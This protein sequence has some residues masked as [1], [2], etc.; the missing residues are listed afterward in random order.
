MKKQGT[1]GMGLSLLML[2]GLA[3]VADAA[4]LA[5][6]VVHSASAEDMAPINSFSYWR[7]NQENGQAGA[8]N[9]TILWANE[10]ISAMHIGFAGTGVGLRVRQ[11]S[12]T[13]EILWRINDGVDGTG[14]IDT[15]YD[16]GDN[17]GYLFYTY[18][19]ASTGTLSAGFHVVSV[20]TNTSLVPDT[21][22]VLDAIEVY[23]PQAAERHEQIYWFFSGGPGTWAADDTGGEANTLA[24]GG[25]ICYTLGEG[26]A[27][28]YRFQGTAAS[29]RVQPRWDWDTVLGWDIDGGFRSGTFDGGDFAD[30]STQLYLDGGSTNFRFSHVL[31]NDLP[32]GAHTLT[33]T[34][35]GGGSNA[36]WSLVLLDALDVID[37]SPSPT[38]HEAAKEGGDPQV[39]YV[40]W[41]KWFYE[42]GYAG[43]SG[44]DQDQ[45]Y[46]FDATVEGG[47]QT[48][49]FFFNGTGVDLGF[50]R[51]GNG[52]YLG[53]SVD[54]GAMTGEY[55]SWWWLATGDRI[56]LPLT[57][58]TGL[59]PGFHKVE[60]TNLDRSPAQIIVM[61]F[62]DV[63]NEQP[64]IKVENTNPNLSYTG[65]WET[66]ADSAAS[67][68]SFARTSD[69]AAT[70]TLPFSGT[71]LVIVGAGG[72]A[73][74]SYTWQIDGGAG[75]SGTV[76][77][78]D[79]LD[80]NIRVP[81]VIVNGL[82]GEEH[83]LVIDHN[84]G[85]GLIGIDFIALSGSLPSTGLPQSD[86][87]AYR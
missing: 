2:A 4:Q 51:Y 17:P 58:S 67:M 65:T 14:V 44:E 42:T 43:A 29:L 32:A 19:L 27:C 56:T 86:W 3:A 83:T 38:R 53:W 31:A 77:Q 34:N 57:G 59:S 6:I 23:D 50:Y 45:V 70:L 68:G 49:T 28:E 62:F 40:H 46:A 5:D 76:N 81:D 82:A 12:N 37:D 22:I 71:D 54:D 11:Q 55:D 25:S 30:P 7:W 39:G 24:S 60:V 80:N 87:P 26:A 13:K 79:P 74:D 75:G 84:G 21:T 10:N 8:Y 72:P 52:E 1:L 18:V 36:A 64:I 48:M 47:T 85:T 69:P 20:S 15:D 9:G 35:L 78:N 61:D 63:Y 16:T 33:L 41:N 73:F 66:F